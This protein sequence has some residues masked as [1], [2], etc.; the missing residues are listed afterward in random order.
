MQIPIKTFSFQFLDREL[1]FPQRFFF[2][3]SSQD[4]INIMC[5]CFFCSLN[6]KVKWKRDLANVLRTKQTIKKK[7]KKRIPTWSSVTMTQ[8]LSEVSSF[9]FLTALHFVRL[10]SMYKSILLEQTISSWPLTSLQVYS[11]FFQ[12]LSIECLVNANPCSMH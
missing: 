12:K 6:I 7:K 11:S 2:P 1:G 5:L 4:P 10:T 9:G 8:I 3:L